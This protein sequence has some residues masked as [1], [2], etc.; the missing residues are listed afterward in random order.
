MEFRNNVQLNPS[1][2]SLT[3]FSYAIYVRSPRLKFLCKQKCFINLIDFN[4]KEKAKIYFIFC[5]DF[6]IEKFKKDFRKYVGFICLF[7]FDYEF[8]K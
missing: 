6:I 5:E 2:T 7:P 3:F 1:K 4:F 8:V